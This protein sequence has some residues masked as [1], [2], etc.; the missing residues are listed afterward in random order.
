M[1]GY[2]Y[3][4]TRTVD[5]LLRSLRG[6]MLFV[7]LNP[8]TADEHTDD[9]TIRRCI[10]FARREQA[11]SIQVVNLYAYRA[12][13]PADLARASWPIGE[14][15]DDVLIEAMRS[16]ARIVCAWGAHPMAIRARPRFRRAHKL[17]GSPPLLCLGTTK[18][19][20]PRHPL[21]VR[22]DAPL[23]PFDGY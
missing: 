6:P 16:D 9:P 12:T 22:A 2:R 17:A 21:Y 20:A 8:S 15:N 13:D 18:G 14:S 4:L 1:S 19:G 11:P 5:P 10:G 7:M 3:T 23:V